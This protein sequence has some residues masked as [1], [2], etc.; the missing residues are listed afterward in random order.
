VPKDHYTRSGEGGQKEREKNN[1]VEKEGET[2]SVSF[3]GNTKV[4]PAREKSCTK[5]L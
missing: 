1:E 2:I 4:A 3:S 5:Q